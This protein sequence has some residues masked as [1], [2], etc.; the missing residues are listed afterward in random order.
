MTMAKLDM[1]EATLLI[2][3]DEPAFLESL[4]S[5]LEEEFLVHKALNGIEA[6]KFLDYATPSLIILDLHLP[7]I[8]GVRLLKK[9]RESGNDKPVI[10]LT[11]N[12]SHEWAKKCADLNVQGYMEKPVDINRLILKIRKL[13]NIENPEL[14]K[15]V[16]GD[17]D[18][19]KI[20]SYSPI[21]RRTI[22]YIEKNYK[23]NIKRG[24]IASYLNISPAYLSRHFHK[25]CG[26]QLNDCINTL[27]VNKCKEYLLDSDK[28][29]GDIA[30][31]VGITD[32]NYLSRLF[33]KYTGLSP[34][35]FRNKHILR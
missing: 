23:K 33:K 5:A 1:K 24:D 4:S 32:A 9:V 22:R 14:L 6:L 7:G 15:E 2:V 35:E 18:K 30:F 10:V 29:I 12:S 27:R 34:L 3:D 20:R 17:D 13:L 11:G 31:L 8:D 25:E 21:A 16:L 28:N 26:I 19:E